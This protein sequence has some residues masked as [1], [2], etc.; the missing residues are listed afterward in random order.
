MNAIYRKFKI[1]IHQIRF[2]E[3]GQLIFEAVEMEREDDGAAGCIIYSHKMIVEPD[4]AKTAYKALKINEND[5]SALLEEIQR[6]CSGYGT[7]R[8]L[9]RFLTSHCIYFLREFYHMPVT[10]KKILKTRQQDELQY[11]FR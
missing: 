8:N 2:N 6:E 1:I 4:Q 10:Y 7:M 11:M 3:K 5:Q 9:E